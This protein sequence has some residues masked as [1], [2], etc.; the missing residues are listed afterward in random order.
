V[1]NMRSEG[2]RFERGRCLV[3]VSWFYEFTGARYPKTKHRF[4]KLRSDGQ[5]EDWFCF[6]GVW[7]PSDEGRFALLTTRPGPDVEPIHD[8]QPVVL[9]RVDWARWLDPAEPAEPL[10]QPS[11]AGTLKLTTLAPKSGPALL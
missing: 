4:D 3:P 6:A 10:L 7:T 1:I 9:E 2:R 8:R 5:P 11:P